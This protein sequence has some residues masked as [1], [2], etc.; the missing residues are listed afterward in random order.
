MED[1]QKVVVKMLPKPPGI[2]SHEKSI[3]GS[4]RGW[5]EKRVSIWTDPKMS[6]LQQLRSS[7]SS[8]QGRSQDATS[9]RSRSKSAF[10]VLPG[11]KANVRIQGVEAV[12]LAT[13]RLAAQVRQA[14]SSSQV[15]APSA[16]PLSRV[17]DSS[18]VEGAQQQEPEGRKEWRAGMNRALRRLMIDMDLGRADAKQNQAHEQLCKHFDKMYSWYERHGQMELC[19]SNQEVVKEPQGPAYLSF[20]AQ[21]PVMAGSMRKSPT[22]KAKDLQKK[23]RG[24]RRLG[25]SSSSP[26]LL[27]AGM[28]AMNAN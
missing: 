13:T 26:A 7:N 28:Q 2:Y 15:D 22:Q 9:G 10:P 12:N 27:S 19:N 3:D 25:D 5:R 23:D 24:H 14:P 4:T 20:D 17:G 8:N 21:G 18:T 6:E 16:I 11:P 1:T